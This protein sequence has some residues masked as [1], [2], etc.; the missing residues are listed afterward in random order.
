MS[1]MSQ[2]RGTKRRIRRARTVRTFTLEQ[3]RA[4][5]LRVMNVVK[6]EGGCVVVDNE[7]NKVFSMWI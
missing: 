6:K 1:I 5:R 2:R 4:N 3:L 7:G